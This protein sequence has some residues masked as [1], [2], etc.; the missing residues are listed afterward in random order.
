MSLLSLQD[1]SSTHAELSLE[2]FNQQL[3]IR[4][5]KFPNSPLLFRVPKQI[6]GGLSAIPMARKTKQGLVRGPTV[7]IWPVAES[8][9]VQ[10]SLINLPGYGEVTWFVIRS[11]FDKA[12]A[13]REPSK[14]N[15][16]D[17]P[18]PQQLD[19]IDG[20]EE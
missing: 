19:Q 6:G 8:D 20:I 3:I 18:V 7:R 17:V 12:L 11:E 15:L 13:E 9:I 2:A 5:A 14:V 1:G 16:E 10:I 4:H